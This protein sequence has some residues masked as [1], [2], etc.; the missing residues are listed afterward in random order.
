MGDKTITTVTPGTHR[1]LRL[2]EETAMLLEPILDTI[3][4]AGGD[5]ESILRAILAAQDPDDIDAPW[6]GQGMRSLVE[7]VIRVHGIRWAPS[8]FTE[9]LGIFLIVDVQLADGERTVTTTG[10]SA[11]VLQLCRLHQQEAFPIDLIVKQGESRK[12]PG[13]KPMHLEVVR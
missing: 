8:D 12:D 9:G 11:I 6:K 13:R 10:S 7:Q 3:P 5:D 2:S 1:L 4:E